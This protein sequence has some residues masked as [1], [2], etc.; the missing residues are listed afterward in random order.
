MRSVT[1]HDLLTMAQDIFRQPEFKIPASYFAD[2]HILTA[3]SR[4]TLMS[5]VVIQLMDL[6]SQSTTPDNLSA[7]EQKIC[8]FLVKKS[9]FPDHA[10]MFK[11]FLQKIREQLTTETKTLSAERVSRD[12]PAKNKLIELYDYLLR[13]SLILH[14][15]CPFF[16]AKKEIPTQPFELLF[17]FHCIEIEI[18]NM[19]EIN[20][21]LS[22]YFRTL[23]EIWRKPDAL[24]T[25]A[26]VA[27]LA[28]QHIDWGGSLSWIGLPRLSYIT[29]PSIK[30]FVYKPEYQGLE[31]SLELQNFLVPEVKLSAE[32]ARAKGIALQLLKTHEK[33]HAALLREHGLTRH[34]QYEEK[35]RDWSAEKE[36][37]EKDITLT[38]AE[39]SI[40]QVDSQRK[41]ALTSAVKAMDSALESYLKTATQRVSL[42]TLAR[43]I[44]TWYAATPV[45]VY[46][47]EKLLKTSSSETS[48]T[49]P[50]SGT[51]VSTE[52]TSASADR[53]M[54]SLSSSSSSTASSMV[55]SEPRRPLSNSLSQTLVA[56]EGK[57]AQP[58][59]TGDTDPLK[60]SST[61]MAVK[62]K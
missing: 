6:R 11:T 36:G 38:F 35:E 60:K 56:G 5:F 45:I 22:P 37:E 54:H 7:E 32:V 12:Y 59:S 10:K 24:K 13:D 51:R 20:D 41:N 57:K 1:R 14:P 50:V 30:S 26:T 55:G 3:V 25:P 39:S 42:A 17:G 4:I 8:E 19:V 43:R 27:G 47:L 52:S 58:P 53:A 9:Q 49:I 62:N 15:G 2:V 29:P 31:F 46:P 23:L 61:S 44:K 34:G 48:G 40:R 18:K 28:A 16:A 33:L 21:A